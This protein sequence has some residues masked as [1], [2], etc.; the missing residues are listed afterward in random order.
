M[1]G[2]EVEII[3]DAEE[4]DRESIDV[5]EDY[6]LPVRRRQRRSE[7]SAVTTLALILALAG[8]GFLIAGGITVYVGFNAGRDPKAVLTEAILTNSFAIPFLWGAS[9]LTPRRRRW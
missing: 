7:S 4:P 8:L 6:S 2:T 5:W 1:A 9:K 3:F